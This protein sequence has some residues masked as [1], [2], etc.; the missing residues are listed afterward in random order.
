MDEGKQ[1]TFNQIEKELKNVTRETDERKYAT[2][3]M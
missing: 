1:F 3:I 2:A